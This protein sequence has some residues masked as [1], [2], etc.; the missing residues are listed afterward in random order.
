MVDIPPIEDI[1]LMDMKHIFSIFIIKPHLL[2]VSTSGFEFLFIF[3]STQLLLLY[4]DIY[5]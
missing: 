2:L 5:Q 1:Q 4:I 3:K